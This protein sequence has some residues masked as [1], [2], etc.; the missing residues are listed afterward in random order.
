MFCK[1]SSLCCIRVTSIQGL[2]IRDMNANMFNTTIRCDPDIE[3]G[4]E[5]MEKYIPAQVSENSGGYIWIM[6]HNI[7]GL[8]QH[9][10]DLECNRDFSNADIICLTETWCDSITNKTELEGFESSHATRSSVFDNSC[11]LFV[12]LARMQHG[13]VAVFHKSVIAYAELKQIANNLEC[14]VFKMSTIV[15]VAAVI[16]RTQKYSIGNFMEAFS[17]LINR[18]E[19]LTDKLVI[20]GDFNQDILKDQTSILRFMSSKGFVQSVR[21]PTTEQGTLIDHMYVK[22]CTGLKLSVVPTYYSYHE[23]IEIMLPA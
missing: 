4:I 15:T 5:A 16:Y 1:W 18:L 11:A 21:I 23:A 12:E 10:E 8:N 14:I 22:G 7:Q 3:K 20:L 13:G 2:Y 19:S 6:Y 9:K 17:C